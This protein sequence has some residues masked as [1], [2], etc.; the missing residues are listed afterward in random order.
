MEFKDD[1]VL[2]LLN[3][4]FQLSGYIELDDATFKV[5]ITISTSGVYFVG[6]AENFR[7]PDSDVIIKEACLDLTISRQTK[8]APKLNVGKPSGP[9]DQTGDTAGTSSSPVT[10]ASKKQAP[11]ASWYFGFKVSG[12]L[13]LTFGSGEARSVSKDYKLEFAVTFSLSRSNKGRWEAL[14]AGKA[15]TTVYLRNIINE[16]PADSLLDA[17]LSDF[18]FIGT[19][20]DNP[21]VPKEI[22]QFPIKKGGK[23]FADH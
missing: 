2:C 3:G 20:A 5:D 23:P 21:D 9:D 4:A 19:N 14:V 22:A 10:G 15:R 1:F 8:E 6:S 16:I 11:E 12:V 13:K 18:T 7:V 17:K